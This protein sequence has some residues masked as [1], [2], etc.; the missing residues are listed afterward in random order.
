[1]EIKNKIGYIDNKN[2]PGLEKVPGGHYVLIRQDN[3]NGT[4]NVNVITSLE[5][6][7]QNKL[8][9]PENKISHIK[10]GNTYP[11]P[12]GDSNLPKWS[13]VKKDI[14]QVSVEN[15]HNIGRYYIDT[16]HV[17][18]LNKYLKK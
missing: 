15:I 12:K 18:I 14:K 4:C 11:I 3:K 16:R 9:Y 13:G 5:R 6:R 17:P 1:M 10:K 8:I 7:E 2:L